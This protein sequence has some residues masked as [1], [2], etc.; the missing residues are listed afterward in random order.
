MSGKEALSSSANLKGIIPQD[1]QL[2][3]VRLSP[4]VGGV[5]V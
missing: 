1:W 4:E 2:R 5:K 3:E